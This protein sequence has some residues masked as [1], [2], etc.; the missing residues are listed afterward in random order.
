MGIRFFL[1][2][3]LFPAARGLG[4]RNPSWV[5]LASPR[6][7]GKTPA[8]HRTFSRGASLGWVDPVSISWMLSE[9]WF[10]YNR[11]KVTTLVPAPEKFQRP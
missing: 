9:G 4:I 8:S 11:Q 2:C 7:L 1:H 6:H 10:R 3:C 5:G